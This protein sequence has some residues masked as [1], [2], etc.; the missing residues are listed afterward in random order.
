M[1]AGIILKLFYFKEGK[2]G[3]RDAVTVPN[4]VFLSVSENCMTRK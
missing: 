3:E 1:I 2:T 4:A